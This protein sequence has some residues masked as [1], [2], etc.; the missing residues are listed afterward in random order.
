MDKRALHFF[1]LC[2][3]SGS[4]SENGKIEALNQAARDSIPFMIAAADDEAEVDLLVRVV[5][6][7]DRAEWH[8]GRPTPVSDFAW[9]DLRADGTTAMGA[10]IRLVS[11]QLQMLP[12]NERGMTPVIVL[13]TDGQPTDDADVAIKELLSLRWGQKAIRCAIAIGHDADE[14]ILR[15]FIGNSELQSSRLLQAQNADQL[16]VLIKWISTVVVSEASRPVS[17][18]MSPAGLAVGAPTASPPE[19]SGLGVGN[20]F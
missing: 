7:S 8:L 16:A 2:D 19:V 4:M 6:F 1:Y 13:I 17:Q 9:S 12:M 10:A 20:V 5:R 18:P 3:C 14:E 15:A 11:S